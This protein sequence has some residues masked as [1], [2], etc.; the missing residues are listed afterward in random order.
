M[1]LLGD[2]DDGISGSG[3]C[4]ACPAGAYGAQCEGTCSSSCLTCDEGPQGTGYVSLS[5]MSSDCVA[6]TL[7][8]IFPSLVL[9]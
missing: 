6:L 8:F 9:A 2:C 1:P 7:S 5:L 4:T 3:E